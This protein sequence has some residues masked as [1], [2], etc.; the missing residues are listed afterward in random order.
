M[1][2]GCY[3]AKTNRRFIFLKYIMVGFQFH[4]NRFNGVEKIVDEKNDHIHAHPLALCEKIAL[5]GLRTRPLVIF[6]KT[7][8]C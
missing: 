5:F 2:V 1:S 4:F 6:G 8:S 3:V 7:V